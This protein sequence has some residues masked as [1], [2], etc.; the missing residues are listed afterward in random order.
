VDIA[1]GSGE[2]TTIEVTGYALGPVKK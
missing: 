2:T 1:P